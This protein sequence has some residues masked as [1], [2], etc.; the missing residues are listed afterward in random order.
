MACNEW[1]TREGRRA[2][3]V[4]A[5]EPE[6]LPARDLAKSAAAQV[7]GAAPQGTDEGGIFGFIALAPGA[8]A[9]WFDRDLAPRATRQTWRPV[10]CDYGMTHPSP[11]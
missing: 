3:L 10:R 4:N 9:A 6:L 5:E 2:H 7:A 1:Q 8:I 11:R